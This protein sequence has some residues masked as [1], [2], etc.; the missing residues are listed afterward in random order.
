MILSIGVFDTCQED[1]GES[2]ACDDKSIGPLEFLSNE[3]H[4]FLF[5]PFNFPFGIYQ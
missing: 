5:H 3:V 1:L 2:L 4:L